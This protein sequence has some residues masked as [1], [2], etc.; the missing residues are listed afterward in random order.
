MD[1]EAEIRQL[2]EKWQ[3]ATRTADVR[4]ILDLMTDD[5][6]FQ[7]PGRPPFGKMEFESMSRHRGPG[8]RPQVDADQRVDELEIVGD[9][10]YMRCSF[11]VVVTPPEGEAIQ[12]VGTTLTIFRK[13]AG[14]WLLA[15]DANLLAKA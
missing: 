7:V 1:D 3:A 13:V 8:A 15:R 12:R 4:R 5:V 6:V 11:R 14:R 9:F 10:A 2:M